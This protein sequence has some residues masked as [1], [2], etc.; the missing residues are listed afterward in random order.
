MFWIIGGHRVATS[1]LNLDLR[2]GAS[3]A[4]LPS[5]APRVARL[6]SPGPIM[7][8]FLFVVGVA[9]PFSLS[10]RLERGDGPRGRLREGVAP[11]GGPVDPGH[12]RSGQ[13][14]GVQAR[15]AETVLEHLAGHRR[16]LPHRDRGPG[17]AA[18]CGEAAALAAAL[19]V[20]T[21]YSCPTC[22]PP[23]TSLGDYTPGETWPSGS[24]RPY[25]AGS[26]TGPITPGSSAAWGSARRC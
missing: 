12:D 18:A 22:R 21:G 2:P 13:P 5:R 8:L 15:R 10:R 11:G 24:T 3:S 1:L 6:H 25:S 4:G 23:A 9:M 19:L 14:A 17:G 7:P 16:R 26:G 20:R